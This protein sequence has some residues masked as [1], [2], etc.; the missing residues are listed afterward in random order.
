MGCGRGILQIKSQI[1]KC[2]AVESPLA[3]WFLVD[4]LVAGGLDSWEVKIADF[5]VLLGKD[6][7]TV[8]GAT[9]RAKRLW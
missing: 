5:V 9:N 4:K 1:E 2:K 8:P 7:K 6:A 3:M